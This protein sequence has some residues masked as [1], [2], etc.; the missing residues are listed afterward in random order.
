MASISRSSAV[1][2]G[3]CSAP[4]SFIALASCSEGSSFFPASSA[5]PESEY[6]VSANT[7]RPIV[8]MSPRNILKSELVR[9]RLP[10]V[11]KLS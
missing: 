3:P 10:T 2:G 6:A 4:G 11:R 7:W 8:P 9:R 5:T 1:G